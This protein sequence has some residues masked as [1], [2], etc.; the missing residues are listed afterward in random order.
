M[1]SAHWDTLVGRGQADQARKSELL[2]PSPP[3]YCPGLPKNAK[4]S[5]PLWPVYNP[6]NFTCIDDGAAETRLELNPGN[7]WTVSYNMAHPGDWR[8]TLRPVELIITSVKSEVLDLNV[9]F[10]T[11]V[12]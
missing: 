11:T 7:A 1:G 2:A 6:N 5:P 4:L 10:T 9:A 3:T 12:E 8:N